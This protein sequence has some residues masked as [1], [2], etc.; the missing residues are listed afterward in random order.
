MADTRFLPYS[1]AAELLRRYD[2]PL[3]PQRL[4]QT[5]EE[6]VAA[7]NELGYPLALKGIATRATHKSDAG[8]LRLHLEDEAAVASASHALLATGSALGLEG[9]L[10]QAMVPPAVEMLAG[11]TV[12]EQFGPLLALGSGGILVELLDDV[13]LRLPPLNKAQARR[14]IAATRSWPLLQGFRGRPPGDVPALVQLLANLS[15]L[16]QAESQRLASLDLNPVMVLPQ[17][18]GVR[19]VDL[20]IAVHSQ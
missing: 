2:I 16:A 12:D 17:S 7:A 5:T 8:L 1:E 6:A 18:Q 11:I 14:M 3:A 10:V 9:L 4:V 15:R 19:V 20:R 13:V